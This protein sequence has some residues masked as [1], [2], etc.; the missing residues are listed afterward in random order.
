MVIL[1]A[2]DIE[3]MTP[4]ELNFEIW[5]LQNIFFNN[6]RPD[7]AHKLQEAWK[8]IDEIYRKDVRFLTVNLTMCRTDAVNNYGEITHC[9]VIISYYEKEPQ[10]NKANH[11][12]WIDKY[13]GHA[14]NLPMAICKAYLN[15]FNKN[16]N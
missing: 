7:Y 9:D 6:N 4:N 12:G 13:Y 16:E 5:E 15:W 11:N 1:I 8:L 2:K 3:D 10:R 14:F